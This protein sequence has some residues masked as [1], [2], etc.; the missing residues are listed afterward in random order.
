MT[1]DYRNTYARKLHLLKKDKDG[2]IPS[3]RS[4]CAYVE[5][6]VQTIPMNFLVDTGACYTLLSTA[7]YER[8]P[9]KPKMGPTRKAFICGNGGR[10]TAEG[11][12]HFKVTLAGKEY[13]MQCYIV[14]L[15]SRHVAILGYDEL[16]NY[17]FII[18]VKGEKMYTRKGHVVPLVHRIGALTGIVKNKHKVKIPPRDKMNVELV[19]NQ[20]VAHPDYTNACLME[21][22]PHLWSRYGLL[23]EPGVTDPTVEK[24]T[25]ILCNP[26][27]HTVELKPGSL[28]AYAHAVDRVIKLENMENLDDYFDDEEADIDMKIHHMYLQFALAEANNPFCIYPE[29]EEEVY[30][31]RH[32]KWKAPNEQYPFSIYPVLDEFMDVDSRHLTYDDAD[33]RHLIQDKEKLEVE[34]I[35]EHL[36]AMF[37]NANKNL[38]SDQIDKVIRVILMFETTFVDPTGAVGRTNAA[39]HLINTVTKEP[40]KQ[41]PRRIAEKKKEVVKEEVL[42]MLEL[43]VVRG[44]NSPWSSPIVLVTK[45]DGTVRFCVDYRKLNEVTKKDAYPLPRIDDILDAL[46][47][48]KYFCTLDL[49]SGYWQV[50]LLEKDKEK[51]AFSTHMGLYEFNVMPFGLT[52]APATFQRMMDKVLH[53]YIGKICLCYL[54]DIVIFGKTF[55]ETLH[56]LELVLTRLQEANLK[57]KPKKCD[58]F[59]ME[60]KYLGYIVSEEGIRADPE[61]CDVIMNWP[62]PKRV[63]HVRSFL[64]TASYYRRFIPDFAHIAKPL[65]NLIG[66]RTTLD[67]TPK[68]EKAMEQLKKTLTSPPVLAFPDFSEPFIVD[69]DAS[70]VAIG[71]VLSQNLGGQ[72]RVICYMSKALTKEQTRWCTTTRELYAIVYSVGYKW[73]HYL[74]G[75][76]FL[77]RTDHSS[78]TWLQNFKNLSPMLHRWIQ[79][80]QEFNFKIEHRPGR[81]HTNAD[82]LSRRPRRPCNREDCPDCS[83]CRSE[84]TTLGHKHLEERVDRLLN[85]L[86]EDY[87][88]NPLRSVPSRGA[89]AQ[90]IEDLSFPELTKQ[91][92]KKLQ[93]EDP[94]IGRFIEL[95]KKFDESPAKRAIQ[96]ETHG[97]KVLCTLWNQLDFVEEVLCRVEGRDNVPCKRIIAPMSLIGKILKFVHANKNSLHWGID[98]TMRI[99]RPLYYWPGMKK[100]VTQWVRQCLPCEMIKC[101]QRKTKQPMVLEKPSV[102]FERVFFDVVTP[103]GTTD[104]GNRYILVLVDHFSKFADAYPL[105]SHTAEV[106][107]NCI[108]N[109][110]I[111]YFGCPRKL[112][113]DRAPE[114]E[115]IVMKHLC[116]MLEVEKTRTTPYH[117][118]SDGAAERMNQTLE[119]MLS[120][121]CFDHKKDWDKYVAG[122]ISI[123]NATPSRATGQSPHLLVFGQEKLM[124]LHLSCGVMEKFGSDVVDGSECYCDIVHRIQ[125]KYQ[126]QYELGRKHLGK[127]TERMK[128]Y[129]DLDINPKKFNPGDWVLRTY[130]PNKALTLGHPVIGPYVVVKQN[131]ETTYTIQMTEDSKTETVH[132]NDLRLSNAMKDKPNWVR[133]RLENE[134]KLQQQKDAEKVAQ[135]SQTAD[136][137]TQISQHK[138]HA[139]TQF[140]EKTAEKSLKLAQ[141]RRST[142]A[143]RKPQRYGV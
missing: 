93:E 90:V 56:N 61:K 52:N 12:C 41:A 70:D 49:A 57:V 22:H 69:T 124:P 43:K 51:T 68:A 142:R 38:D 2:Y 47:G 87:G 50:G 88:L 27:R 85:P 75:T 131:A 118:Q 103:G 40:I 122:C 127:Y 5:A 125:T 120:A 133:T 78:L 132:A 84:K 82:G 55:E 130:P 11:I 129:Y 109:R 53:G 17:G 107:A 114:F 113:C 46:R 1:T 100:Q 96:G 128:V 21:T 60:I 83:T 108:V 86:E 98:K 63:G 136:T 35:A 115:G 102:K 59:H 110:W 19:N 18:D 25:L 77:I 111:K 135:R 64:G 44:S 105:P 91:D 141:A 16:W 48:A 9:K 15:G 3:V 140:C 13:V 72:E 24:P 112:H 34:D 143:T 137:G 104:A 33:N 116:K 139:A 45:K 74:E 8:L 66:K 126:Y 123:Y 14:D 76:E 106:V 39:V 95:R 67:W 26:S 42:R 62:K 31:R 121:C 101:A 65:T 80:L 81:K 71:A 89:D 10:L 32:D 6:E 134:K 73:R 4:N 94:V 36:R 20:W 30:D 23:V 117:P 92:I 29:I 119:R 28:I 58:L 37:K 138:T 7:A 79:T 99:L 54:D 97:V